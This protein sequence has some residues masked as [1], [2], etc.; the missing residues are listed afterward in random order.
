MFNQDRNSLKRLWEDEEEN[1][2]LGFGEH[3]TVRP[4]VAGSQ[5][6]KT[7]SS[8][9]RVMQALPHS[10]PP[11]QQLHTSS[12][13]SWGGNCR[14]Q[15]APP[16]ITPVDSDSEDTAV[17]SEPRLCINSSSATMTQN[18]GNSYSPFVQGLDRIDGSQYTQ[19]TGGPIFSD[20]FDDF[21]MTDSV[22][23]S[24]GG[25]FQNDLPPAISGRVPTPIHS[26]FAPAVRAEKTSKYSVSGDLM[27]D[28]DMVDRFRRGR[29]LP[30]PISEGEM[31]PSVIVEGFG[32]MQMDVEA[33]GQQEIE[34][35]T[36]TKKGHNRSK[37]S[38]RQ[39]TGPGYGENG[40]AGGMKRT[41]SMGYR[42]DCEKCRLRVPGHFSHIITY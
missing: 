25:S 19:I 27:D 33:T 15:P 22:H 26:S 37:H 24:P 18:T 8:Q 1:S 41:F 5:S 30:S 17:A 13:F 12:T 38:L 29:R 6:L 23:P 4:P 36:P 28:E 32:E 31:S 14:F 20:G 34:R 39:W 16:T 11:K 35:E 21:T 9:K 2:P 42:S 40:D 10:S 7:D 3:R